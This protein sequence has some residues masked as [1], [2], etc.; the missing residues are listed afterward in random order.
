[1]KKVTEAVDEEVSGHCHV[2]ELAKGTIEQR[3]S[4]FVG[5]KLKLL[6]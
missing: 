3:C 2:I 5:L 6:E 4:D 1:L